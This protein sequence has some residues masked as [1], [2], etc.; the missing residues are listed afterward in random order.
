MTARFEP[1]VL[2]PYRPD[3]DGRDGWLLHTTY[4][5]GFVDDLKS[6]LR[7][8]DRVWLPDPTTAWWI[9]A[10]NFDVVAHIVSRYFG[11]YE[12]I[13]AESGELVIVEADGGRYRQES[14]L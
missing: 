12:I 11:A 14:A 5:P 6:R 3:G 1:Y 13:D 10:D 2:D 8:G 7:H 9:A 4:H